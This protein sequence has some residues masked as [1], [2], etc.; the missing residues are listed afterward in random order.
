MIKVSHTDRAVGLWQVTRVRVIA[1]ER[2]IAGIL[3]GIHVHGSAHVGAEC[4]IELPSVVS[5]YRLI[6]LP[7]VCTS[8]LLLRRR[9]EEEA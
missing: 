9:V 2:I 3:A 6:L 8:V 5:V 4:P 7:G 1:P